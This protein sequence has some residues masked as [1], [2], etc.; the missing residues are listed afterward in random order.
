[1]E[2]APVGTHFAICLY[3]DVVTEDGVKE[4]MNRRVEV[5]FER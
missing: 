1:M 4:R 3:D 5:M 2:G